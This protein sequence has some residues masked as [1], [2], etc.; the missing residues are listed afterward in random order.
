MP[1]TPAEKWGERGLQPAVPQLP[2][3]EKTGE[4]FCSLASSDMRST[5]KALFQKSCPPPN[6]I[7]QSSK[8]QKSPGK[9][10]NLLRANTWPTSV[11]LVR[12]VKLTW[13]TRLMN[14]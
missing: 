12:Q 9:S 5:C 10:L 8:V 4:G 3:P 11:P 6:V 1:G 2:L 13:Q 14:N 7:R